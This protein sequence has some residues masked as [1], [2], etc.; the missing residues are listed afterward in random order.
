[1]VRVLVVDDHP[2]VRKGIVQVFLSHFSDAVV[3]EA[4]SESEALEAIRK[5]AWNLI[6]LDLSLP[7]RGGLDLLKD[8]KDAHATVPVLIVSAYPES[9]FAVRALRAGA[10]GYLTKESPPEILIEASRQIMDG[11]RYIT[12]TIADLLADNLGA[13]ASRQP[14]ELLS[15]R[16]YEVMIRIAKGESPTEIADSLSLS[17]KTVAT[18]RVR[19]L[20][21]MALKNN[22]DLMQYAIR[23]NLA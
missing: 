1:M 13:D 23:R 12:P 14:H 7:G 18:Y 10:S 22:A 8:L 20:N 11:A 19:I 15:D 3:G 16:E 17:V 6:V 2:L 21:K 9:Q 4:G 5:Q